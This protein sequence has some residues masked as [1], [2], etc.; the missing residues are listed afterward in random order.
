MWRVGNIEIFLDQNK[1]VYPRTGAVTPQVHI[2]PNSFLS[3]QL[4]RGAGHPAGPQDQEE[5]VAAIREKSEQYN[6]HV[7]YS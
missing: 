2:L 5:R 1:E 6:Q 4:H 7:I 3:D